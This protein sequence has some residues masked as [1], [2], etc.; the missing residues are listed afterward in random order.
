MA[1]GDAN[2]PTLGQRDPA[3]SGRHS[4][5]TPGSLGNSEPRQPAQ[6]GL[7]RAGDKNFYQL[8]PRRWEGSPGMK[9]LPM[10]A[11]DSGCTSRVLS[12]N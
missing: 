12:A 11:S 10:G 4:P 5:W 1:L 6:P 8:A 7:Q 2:K 3:V 9:Q